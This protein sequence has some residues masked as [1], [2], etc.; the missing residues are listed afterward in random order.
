M[1]VWIG[2][3][4]IVHHHG[5]TSRVSEELSFSFLNRT[6][7][8]FII[9]FKAVSRADEHPATAFGAHVGFRSQPPVVFNQ[10]RSPQIRLDLFS[11][12]THPIDPSFEQID[13]GLYNIKAPPPQS[14]EPDLQP[15]ICC[16]H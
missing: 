9:M 13:L 7:T 8:P 15:F 16:T 10:E 6:L 12:E 4:V 11:P 3:V 5:R 14:I 1:P 2:A